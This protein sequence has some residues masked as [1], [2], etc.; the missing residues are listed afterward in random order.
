MF[1]MTNKKYEALIGRMDRLEKMLSQNHTSKPKQ[2]FIVK[3]PPQTKKFKRR[4]LKPGNGTKLISECVLDALKGVY[5]MS[6]AHIYQA[7][8]TGNSC[9][10]VPTKASVS[11]CLNLMARN[12]EIKACG[13]G[14]YQ[15]SNVVKAS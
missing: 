7:I 13:N 10:V 6:I 15:L 3:A 12:G 9:H 1:L 5:Q 2:S 8:K 14:W 4:K 11:T